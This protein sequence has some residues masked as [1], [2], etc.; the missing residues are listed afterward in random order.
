MGKEVLFL[1]R[2][3]KLEQVRDGKM[4]VYNI[5]THGHPKGSVWMAE[6]IYSAHLCAS[7]GE[8]LVWS[9]QLRRLRGGCDIL[10]EPT[11]LRSLTPFWTKLVVPLSSP[12]AHLLSSAQQW[13][14]YGCWVRGV[15][16]GGKIAKVMSYLATYMPRELCV[17]ISDNSKL[18]QFVSFCYLM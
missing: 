6:V 1:H 5:N 13:V 15:C 10:R 14:L 18:A 12:P 8:F 2:P 7:G 9:L 3:I 16:F 17:L 11:C 4:P